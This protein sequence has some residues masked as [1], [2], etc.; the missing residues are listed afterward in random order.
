MTRIVT[1]SVRSGSTEGAERSVDPSVAGS[2]IS[3]V[4]PAPGRL[5]HRILPPCCL[6]MAY[7]LAR[8]RPVPCPTP[9]VVKKG[10]KTRRRVASVM[11]GPLSPTRMRTVPAGVVSTAMT[12]RGAAPTASMI[13]SRALMQR[14]RTACSIWLSRP[15]T[16]GTSPVVS[17]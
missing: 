3:N 4:A 15:A 5:S 2:S 14:F 9:L 13:A 12:I 6:T 17:T 16:G 8:P 10:S 11:P 1:A 7:A